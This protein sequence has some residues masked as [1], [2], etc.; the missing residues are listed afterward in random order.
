MTVEEIYN[1]LLVQQHSCN[2][3]NGYTLSPYH[4]RHF[5]VRNR[6]ICPSL[7]GF[8]K[9][10]TIVPNVPRKNKCEILGPTMHHD[11]EIDDTTDEQR[12][13]EIMTFYNT[14]EGGEDVCDIM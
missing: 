9:D 13:L 4:Y 10:M 5:F 2:E 8:N 1:R 7:F 11:D 14:I 6:E 12:K 3:E